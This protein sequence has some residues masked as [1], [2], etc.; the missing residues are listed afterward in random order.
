MSHLPRPTTREETPDECRLLNE[1]PRSPLLTVER[2]TVDDSGRPIEWG[3]HVYRPSRY[4]FDI[5][6]VR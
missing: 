5:T 6:L 4:I 3:R 2:L 1:P